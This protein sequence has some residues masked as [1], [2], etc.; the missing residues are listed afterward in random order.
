MAF[1]K[2][3]LTIICAVI[4]TETSGVLHISFNGQDIDQL[5]DGD[6]IKIIEGHDLLFKCSSSYLNPSFV[7]TKDGGQSSF[8]SMKKVTQVQ[9]IDNGI[10][11]CNASSWDKTYQFQ[12]F[13]GKSVTVEILYPPSSPTVDPFLGNNFKYSNVL[14]GQFITLKCDSDAK[15]KPNFQW[16]KNSVTGPLI[17]RESTYQLKVA[18]YTIDYYCIVQN[19]MVPTLG[20][21]IT[22]QY[23]HKLQ[24]SPQIKAY[25][26]RIENSNYRNVNE[27]DNIIVKCL[28]YGRPE[29]RVW[30]TKENDPDFYLENNQLYKESVSQKF[31]GTYYC[32]VENTVTAFN[33]SRITTTA[34]EAVYITVHENSQISEDSKI[35]NSIPFRSNNSCT[36]MEVENTTRNT[37]LF[38]LTAIGWFG[39]VLCIVFH[40]I[41]C[42]RNR[43]KKQDSAMRSASFSASFNDEPLSASS[44]YT[45][46]VRIPGSCSGSMYDQI[47]PR[48]LS[49]VSTTLSDSNQTVLTNVSSS[50]PV[51]SD[52]AAY[53]NPKD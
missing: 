43:I 44:T 20:E 4:L 50:D 18:T 29:P 24:I 28:A 34:K 10:Y 26:Y 8:G 21:A 22:T 47:K 39:F 11:T 41:L 32:N 45:N 12:T 30:W 36:D 16:R 23:T 17:T 52:F 15:P 6:P 49:V 31:S 13:E 3:Y 46:N 33:Q 48:S 1:F 53:Q 5:P 2:L 14:N 51:I 42:T 27:G 40:I 9:D 38:I 37:T 35:D 19:R 7:W 25:I